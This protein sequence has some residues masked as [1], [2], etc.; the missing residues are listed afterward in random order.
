MN[1]QREMG[2]KRIACIEILEEMMM[3][4]PVHIIDRIIER[5]RINHHRSGS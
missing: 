3:M 5:M 1:R 2:K 4:R